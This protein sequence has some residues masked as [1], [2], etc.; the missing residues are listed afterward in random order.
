MTFSS[1]KLIFILLTLGKSKLTLR[2]NLL[3]LDESQLFYWVRVRHA[4]KNN[5]NPL[6]LKKIQESSVGS[7]TFQI[8]F[9]DSISPNQNMHDKNTDI[10]GFTG[11]IF[12]WLL[13]SLF[14]Q[15]YQEPY[16]EP[17]QKSMVELFLQK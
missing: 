16:L 17:N 2:S 11:Y 3:T 9:N 5:P 14:W 6:S 8:I 1:S 10:K 4:T 15:Y 13:F 7:G 12:K